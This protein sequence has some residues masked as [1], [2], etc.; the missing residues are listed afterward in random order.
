MKVTTGVK[1]DDEMDSQIDDK[2]NAELQDLMPAMLIP[3]YLPL[4][5]T[6][7]VSN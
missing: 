2:P 6:F 4:I 7:L 5:Y 1:L 3:Y